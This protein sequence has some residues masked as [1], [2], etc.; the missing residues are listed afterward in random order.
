MISDSDLIFAKQIN[1]VIKTS[2]FHLW[3]L[4]KVRPFLCFKDSQRTIHAFISSRLDFCNGLYTGVS[5]SLVNRLELVQN[6]AA[7]TTYAPY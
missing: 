4:A 1:A 7:Q 3:L 5:L 2:F 6:A